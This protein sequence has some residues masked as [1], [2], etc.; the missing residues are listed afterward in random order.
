MKPA[1]FK[2][3]AAESVEEVLDALIEHGFDAKVL[4]GGQSLIPTMNFRMAQPAVLIDL[5]GVPDLGYIKA[6][7]SGGLLFG[8]M[9]RHRAVERDASVAEILPLLHDTMPNIAHPQIR[10]RGTFGGSLVHADPAAELPAVSLALEAQLR[11]RNKG[12]D[13]VVPAS[14]FFL[15]MF[16]T[17]L[18]P[19]EL[20]VEIEVPALPPKSG[21]DFRE[22]SRRHGD[23]ALAGV[24]TVVTLN[25]V[26]TC[27]SARIA[28]LSVGEGPVRAAKAEA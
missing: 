25:D 21:W 14:E 7:E 8:A 3:I 1:P 20:L 16:V 10:N 15:G 17:A 6:S 2:Y 19:E 26:G 12:G 5:N 24:A 13:R 22:V 18:E 4:A 27:A 23:Y 28:L 9:T 11:I